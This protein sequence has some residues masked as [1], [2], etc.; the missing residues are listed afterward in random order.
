[1]AGGRLRGLRRFVN[2]H[3]HPHPDAPDSLSCTLGPSVVSALWLAKPRDVTVATGTPRARV[4]LEM[5]MQ[6]VAVGTEG[7]CGW[8]LFLGDRV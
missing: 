5:S 7:R 3:C 1:M 4:S 6:A 8:T 2:L